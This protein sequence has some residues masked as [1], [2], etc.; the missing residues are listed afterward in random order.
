M[1]R[2]VFPSIIRSYRLD[3]F[4]FI[5]YH[6]TRFGRSFR[7]SSGVLNC[8]HSIRYI[9]YRLV[10]Y[11]LAGTRWNYFHLVPASKQSTNLYDIYLMLCVQPRTPDHGRKDRPKHV[12]W[13]SKNSKSVHLVHN[14]WCLTERPSE[15]Y[16]VIFNTL[17]N[18]ASSWFYYRNISRCTVPWTS[19]LAVYY[20]QPYLY[21][22]AISLNASLRF[23]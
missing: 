20:V 3:V 14:S 16:R 13:Y 17:E 4:E 12:E 19:N 7:T 10:D 18:C 11:L 9:S 8:K 21:S 6:S 22:P 2:T 1:F 23:L 5:E 15:T